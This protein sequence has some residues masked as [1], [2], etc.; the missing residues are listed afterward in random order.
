MP[1]EV[2]ASAKRTASSGAGPL[3]GAAP[4]PVWNVACTRPSDTAS[5][6]ISITA[7]SVAPAAGRLLIQAV[8][9][10]SYRR[11]PVPTTAVV[12]RSTVRTAGR[13][14]PVTASSSPPAAS[15][16]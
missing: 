15:T 8:T 16:P 3:P 7:A 4:S 1:S 13:A 2:A 14:S 5:S 11:S 6:G 10:Q 12:S 9:S